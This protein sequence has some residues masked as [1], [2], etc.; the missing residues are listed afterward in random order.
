M[1]D[2]HTPS[3]ELLATFLEVMRT[4]SLSAAARS[5]RVAQPT[6]R[7]RVAALEQ[8]LGV[9]LFTRSANGLQPTEAAR[10]VRP[11]AEAMEATARTLVRT[12]R[13]DAD[14]AVG[15][16]RIAAPELVG[17]EVLPAAI[18]ALRRRH[19]GLQVE[20]ALSNRVVDLARRDA[21]I[22]VRMAPLTGSSLVA[23]KVG[24][25]TLGWFASPAYLQGRDP[26]TTLDEL[27]SHV[28][29]GYDTDPQLL[30]ALSAQGL[31]LPPRAF[32]VR[33]DHDGAYLGALRAGAGVGV[34]HV[35]LAADPPLVRLL[36]ELG[37]PVDVWL[38][39]H[40]DLRSEPRIQA[41]MATLSEALTAFIAR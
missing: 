13:S 36:P 21:D 14:R 3:W 37:Q 4:G 33:T 39:T 2:E 19:P 29:V 24:A 28:L 12:A 25:S 8:G 10:R 5:L 1:S 15:T 41:T 20:L 11:L 38:V 23:R 34:T 6:A 17:A 18:A 32:A 27:R 22:A 30:D 31:P 7:R 35:G 16:V 9:V 26:P 40:E